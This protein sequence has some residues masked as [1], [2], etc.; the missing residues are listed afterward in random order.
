MNNELI[1]EMKKGNLK[2]LYKKLTFANLLNWFAVR[3]LR[4]YT[5]ICARLILYAIHLDPSR[6]VF[7]KNLKDLN[8][9]NASFHGEN[10]K[11]IFCTFSDVNKYHHEEVTFFYTDKAIRLAKPKVYNPNI[12]VPD[13]YACTAYLPDAYLAI[14]KDAQIFAGTDLI[15]VGNMAIYDEI[16][17]EELNQSAIKS[18][19][20]SA[21][22]A[23]E[24]TINMPKGKKHINDGI[25]LTKDHSINYFHWLIECL[26]R[27]SLISDLNVDIPLLVDDFLPIQ[28][29]DALDMLNSGKRKIIRMR[30]DYSYIIKKL[31][32]PSRLSIVRDNYGLPVYDKD[33]IYSAEGV[34]FVRKAIL[35]KIS[36]EVEPSRKIFISRKNSSYRQLLNSVEVE[37]L[38]VSRGFE[39]VFPENLSFLSQVKI[40]SQAKI[41][42]GQSG[43]GM[44]NFIFAPKTAK[45]LMMLSDAPGSNLQLFNALAEIVGIHLEYLIG[46]TTSVLKKYNLHSD[47]HVD[48][49]LLEDYLDKERL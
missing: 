16:N 34:Q 46:K 7:R 26:S 12:T 10:R 18:P 4:A 17:K 20:V 1:T 30:Q 37:N 48:I 47:F 6:E 43:A 14:V 28:F 31:Y 29:Y 11:F 39:I 35:A 25:H 5:K 13:S 27:L 44:A 32:Y 38:L 23:N 19:I 40:F 15:I 24:M 21:V 42:I 3:S 22:N 41:I 8:L 36:S 33:A 49:N 9:S 2:V 45:V